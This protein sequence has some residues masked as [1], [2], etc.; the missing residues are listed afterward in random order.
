MAHYNTGIKDSMPSLLDISSALTG[1]V[2]DF[3]QLVLGKA[4][5][6][7]AVASLADNDPGVYDAKTHCWTGKEGLRYRIPLGAIPSERHCREKIRNIKI[8]LD[9]CRRICTEDQLPCTSEE[10]RF[11]YSYRFMKYQMLLSPSCIIIPPLY[12]FWKMFHEKLPRVVRGRSVPIFL[13]LGLAEQW[14]EATFPAHQLLST[15]LK[16]TTP[17]GDAARA[18]WVRLQPVD[19]PFYLYTSYQFHHFFGSL[20][21]EYLFGGNIAALCG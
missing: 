6:S 3:I 20:P 8:L 15:A 12:I 9:N 7:F 11:W 21:Q 13:G 10:R 5:T 16:A 2:Q 17:M 18:E 1:F 14:A 19:I 4:H